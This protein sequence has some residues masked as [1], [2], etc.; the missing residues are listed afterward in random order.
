MDYAA[1]RLTGPRPPSRLCRFVNYFSASSF[2]PSL[3]SCQPVFP[4][5]A[6]K[7]GKRYRSLAI[8]VCLG[9]LFG[10]LGAGDPLEDAFHVARNKLRMHQASGQVV[11]IGVDERSVAEVGTATWSERDLTRLL[12]AVR[13][14]NPR[15]VHFDLDPTNSASLPQDGLLAKEM[16]RLGSRLSLSTRFAIDPA[17][18]QRS[19][20]SPLTNLARDAPL[21]NVNTK[22]GWDN[23]VRQQP[24]AV[25]SHGRAVLSLPAY[26]AGSTRFDTEAVFPIDYAIDLRSIPVLSASDVING[27]FKAAQLAGKDVVVSRTD[28][29]ARRYN[30]PGYSVVPAILIQIVAAETLI[31]GS[32]IDLGWVAAFILAAVLAYGV[33]QSSTRAS[34]GVTTALGVVALLTIPLWLESV[35]VHL[36]VI[37]S[38]VVLL[39]AGCARA[40]AE[41][42]NHLHRRGNTNPVSGLPNLLALLEIGTVA[43]GILVSLRIQNRSQIRA[44]L[45]DQREKELVEQVVNRLRFGANGSPVYQADDG[46]FVWMSQAPE[47][48]LQQQLDGLYALFRSPAVVGARLLDVQVA[49]GYD[50]DEGRPL[51]QR[52]AGTLAAADEAAREGLRWKCFDPAS[53]DDAEW[54]LSLLS[55]LDQA[56]EAGQLWVAYQPKLDCITGVTVGAEA[57]VRW[58][59]PEKGNIFP[60]QFIGAAERSGRIA[61]LTRFVLDDA[62][63]TASHINGL[64]RKFSVAVNL[65]A[66]LLA[67]DAIISMVRD[68]IHKYRFAPDLLVLEITETSTLRSGAEAEEVLRDL[69]QMGVQLSIDDYGT[70]FS[71]LEYLKR[72]P[73]SEI[74]IDRTFISMLHRSQSDRIMVNSTIQLAHS[75]GRKVVAEGV[76]NAEIL[77]ELI[78]MGCDMVQGYHTARPMPKWALHS[79]LE[80]NGTDNRSEALG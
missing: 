77:D 12:S 46:T 3:C 30:A 62:V 17:T 78:W 64:G 50:V 42:R 32:P 24:F 66:T 63:S 13:K 7:F 27:R 70:G 4:W 23:V 29:D 21:V 25:R 48:E 68:T 53:L 14:V 34:A 51:S 40:W 38:I 69:S 45:E 75:L 74:K 47:G 67:G 76:E 44:S 8:V 33:L 35:Q 5:K 80:L 49:F 19:E 73:A 9:A 20:S 6:S 16:R 15:R 26:L 10:V 65:S 54:T 36:V 41:W 37:P 28:V 11:L 52:I 31:S 61:E 2:C 43:Q 59:H 57:L 1:S 18:G 39:G 58:T 60:D 71:T 22:I 79:F 56:L 72:V 55:R